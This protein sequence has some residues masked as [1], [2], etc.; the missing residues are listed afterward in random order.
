MSAI[1]TRIAELPDGAQ[2]LHAGVGRDGWAF[3]ALITRTHTLQSGGACWA[4]E[5]EWSREHDGAEPFR[6]RREFTQPH[7]VSDFLYHL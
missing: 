7:Y 2:L 5:V 3:D 4:I 1:A 6:L